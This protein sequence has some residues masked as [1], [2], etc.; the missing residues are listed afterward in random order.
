M[1]NNRSKGLFLFNND[2]RL[3]DQPALK[4]AGDNTAE[5]LCVYVIDEG[6]KTNTPFFRSE[7]GVHRRRF[8]FETLSNLDR[9]L[10]ALGQE[11]IVVQGNTHRILSSLIQSYEIDAVFASAITGWYER[12]RWSQ[13]QRTFPTV[14]FQDTESQT[15]FDRANLPFELN[16][17]PATF[18]KFRKLIEE[19][20]V[21]APIPEI[22]TLPPPPPTRSTDI[23][24]IDID[25]EAR[26]HRP[27]RAPLFEGGEVAGLAHLQE[28]FAGGHASTYKET[29]NALSDWS[30]STKMSPWL[31]NGSFSPRMVYQRLRQFEKE[32]EQNESTY[33]IYFE[34]LWREYFQWYEKAHDAKLFAFAGIQQRK[35]LTSFYPERVQKWISGQTPFPLVNACMNELAAEGYIS[36]RARQIVASCLVNEL[37]V[38]WRFGA[39]YFQEVLIDHDLGS[40]WGNWQYIAGVGA[41][42]R[43]GRHFDINKQQQIYDPENSYIEQWTKGSYSSGDQPLPLDSVDAADWPI[44]GVD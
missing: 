19:Q 40:N 13:L 38:D 26:S 10:R 32:V 7:F 3:H 29:R 21:P 35:P 4:L 14:L 12:K 6:W 16:N 5:L 44:S 30:T 28:Y 42:P 11:L 41:D 8:L 37:A 34:L 23:Q 20:E 22:S 43:G 9:Q 24:P 31:A 33:W 15:L 39:A 1:S 17:L 36:N 27:D 2:L 25:S 18:S